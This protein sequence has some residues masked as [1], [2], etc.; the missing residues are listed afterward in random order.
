MHQLNL[1]AFNYKIKKDA[2]GRHLIFDEVRKNWL[3]LTPE[4]WV[5]QH[6][7]HLLHHNYG[8]PM[9]LISLEAGLKVSGRSKRS[10]LVVFKNQK[11]VILVECKAPDIRISQSTLSQALNYNKVYDV[12]IL[13][14]TN[15]L[16]HV[17]LNKNEEGKYEQ[18]TELPTFLLL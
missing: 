3:V 6:W 1:P 17:F 15:G 8:C 7:V 16:Q 5:R 10:D 4:E 12:Q 11:P 2:S 9:G 14:L 18:I 13:V